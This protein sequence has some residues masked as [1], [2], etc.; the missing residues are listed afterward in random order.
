VCDEVVDP[1][2]PDQTLDARG[3]DTPYFVAV[4]YKEVPSRP[5]RVQ[6]VGCGCDDT[7]CEY[8]RWRDG[9][10]ICVLDECPDS[11]ADPLEFGAF[12]DPGL[13]PDCPP[14]PSDPWVVLAQVTID[15]DGNVTQVDN[16]ACRRMFRSLAPYWWKCGEDPIVV[17]V[18]TP[19][20]P[21]GGGDPAP[22]P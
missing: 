11:H 3:A 8:S 4:R 6:P 10:E 1:L 22:H 9:Y 2:C 14:C 16:C 5:V 15:A 13:I 18:T 12:A 21:N 19:P 20:P 17:D 7:S